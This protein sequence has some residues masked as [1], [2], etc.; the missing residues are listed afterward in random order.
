MSNQIRLKE[1]TNENIVECSNLTIVMGNMEVLSKA[2]CSI[3][4][5]ALT[6]L[7]GENGSGKTSLVRSI[8]GLT[9]IKNGEISIN[10]INGRAPVFGYVPQ[11]IEFPKHLQMTVIEYLQYSAAVPLSDIKS[12]L[13]NVDF[14]E[15]HIVSRITELSGGQV[16][17]LLLAAELF[18]SP[19]ILF[20]DE[21]LSNVDSTSERHII[22][23]I[24]EIK[25][26]GVSIV[27]ITHDW[28]V[29]S[30]YANHVICLNKNIIC[31]TSESCICRNSLSKINIKNIQKVTSDPNSTHEGYCYIQNI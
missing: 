18:R 16:Q 30:V 1:F 2:S 25:N 6:F 27:I 28:Q 10:P 3:P 13:Q 31:E 23:V 15:T 9:P 29:I 20:L 24:M 14:P 26:Q 5:N 4:K 17:K 22:D 12:T 7:V 11:N 19:D 21:P 8:L